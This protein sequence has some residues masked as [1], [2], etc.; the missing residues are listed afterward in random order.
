MV[1]Q[2]AVQKARS[3]QGE[4]RRTIS[5]FT[6]FRKEPTEPDRFYEFLADDTIERLRAYAP[7]ADAVVL[8]VGGGPGYVASALRSAGAHCLV[9]EYSA[10]ELV[11]HGRSPESAIRADGQALPVRSAGV[12]VCHSS[13]VL[14]H[15]PDPDS[16]LAEMVRVVR[17]GGLIYL[18]FTN[19]LSPWGGHETSPWHYFG[20]DWAARRWQAKHGAAPKN[21]FGRSLYRVDVSHVL[22][23]VRQRED[24]EILRSGSRYLPSWTRPIL[25]IPGIRELA[26]WNLELILRRR[27][28]SVVD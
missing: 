13:N 23:W 5:L 18:S 4:L 27:V 24:I 14:E 17:P 10:A 28:E 26:V 11:L 21:H 16:M 12:D 19:W 15:V 2:A 7:I 9:A 8:D 25:W 3:R 20:G 6:L 1:N 22:R